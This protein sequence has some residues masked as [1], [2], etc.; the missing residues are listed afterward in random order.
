MGSFVEPYVSES[1]GPPLERLRSRSP[2]L[3]R[4]ETPESGR[5][6]LEAAASRERPSSIFSHGG[7][8]ERE[9]AS[10]FYDL[11]RGGAGQPSFPPHPTIGEARRR[12]FGDRGSAPWEDPYSHLLGT[13]VEPSA[14]NFLQTMGARRQEL[15]QQG[16]SRFLG[17][18]PLCPGQDQVHRD[19]EPQG[20]GQLRG[21]PVQV[22]RAGAVPPGLPHTVVLPPVPEPEPAGSQP[23]SC[24]RQKKKKKSAAEKAAERANKEC[25]RCHQLGH[26]ELDCPQPADEPMETAHGDASA[27]VTPMD[28]SPGPSEQ[29]R[30]VE[31]PASSSLE[32]SSRP[33]TAGTEEDPSRE[34]RA[35]QAAGARV[36]MA[37]RSQRDMAGV[38]LDQT[39]S[40]AT[41]L[42]VEAAAS[43]DPR[44]SGRAGQLSVLKL[45][46]ATRRPGSRSESRDMGR[47]RARNLTR[48]VPA[49]TPPAPLVHHY[50]GDPR[51]MFQT[52]K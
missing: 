52:L 10:A 32:T 8:P 6:S 12:R 49:P 43:S 23:K 16:A 40:S 1:G 31:E 14:G 26:Y 46:A 35:R 44:G 30:P 51:A 18:G 3:E 39:L 4:P 24:R 41:G 20:G 11:G 15:Y 25:W 42:T 36:A 5:R 47:R 28:V 9:S 2:E 7:V 34:E 33:A 13:P 29:G 48:E 45:A 38:S 21:A 19:P 37:H 22:V 50:N 27:E 17:S